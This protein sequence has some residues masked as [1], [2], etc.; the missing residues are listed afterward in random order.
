VS[1]VPAGRLAY[2]MQ[3]P[4]QSQSTVY[5]Q[6]W[7]TTAG[8]DELAA[9]ARKA[10]ETGFF[11]VAVCDHV[12]IP[13]DK[14]EAMSTTWYDTFTTLG[15]LAGVTEWVRLLSH[16]YVPAYRHP[17]V[18]A[19]ALLTLDEVSGG[20]AI[21]GVGAG[22]V[23]AEFE[24]LGVDFA[25]RGRLLDESI[26]VVRAA[27][28]DEYPAYEGAR[29]SV[30]DVGLRPRPRQQPRPPIW[31]GGSSPAALRRAGER[32][33]GWLP[34]G[35]PPGQYADMIQDLLRHRQAAV[36]DQPVDLGAL[37]E[38]IHVGDPGDL[39]M[40]RWALTG[41]AE[42]IAAGLHRWRERGADHVQVRFPSRSL[43][44]LL[45]QME[46]FA[47]EVAPLLAD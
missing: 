15:F 25:R 33:D 38:L 3:L 37:V 12:A 40:G 14:A 26:D 36:G 20:R 27:L 24:A 9:I 35:N 6:E 44:E 29:F 10:D 22:H 13:R 41:S 11:Y 5:V 16:V 2:G 31:V 30:S 18:T 39:D 42:E 1:I 21:L 19:K 28:L 17:L 32:G 23:E 34:Q 8:A 46:A 4:V 7:E 47:A 45:E 43:A